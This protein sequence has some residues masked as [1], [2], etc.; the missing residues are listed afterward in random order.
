[1]TRDFTDEPVGREVIEEC[2]GLAAR[3]PSAGKTQGWHVVG[4][5]G[6]DTSLYWDAALPVS[7][8]PS[9]SPGAYLDRYTEPDKARTGLG[10]GEDAWPAPYWTIDGAMATMTFLHALHDVDLGAL[11]FAVANVDRVRE[12]LGIPVDVGIIGAVAA[13]HP[14]PRPG[15]KGASASRRGRTGAETVRWGGW[16]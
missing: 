3:S 13:G 9:V 4:L 8:R 11:F 1:M 5:L 14:S 7:A 10:A 2:L 16:G 6:A 15:R 12:A